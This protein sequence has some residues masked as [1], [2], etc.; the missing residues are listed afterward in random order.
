MRAFALVLA[1]KRAL[2][3]DIVMRTVVAAWANID[4]FP[5][6]SNMRVWLF[7]M[8]R[9]VYYA[10]PQPAGRAANDFGAVGDRLAPRTNPVANRA[11]TRFLRAFNALPVGQR[12][13]LV[14]TGPEG[15]SLRDA[16]TVCGCSP[17]KIGSHV[18]VGHRRLAVVLSMD[19]GGAE[20]VGDP[21]SLEVICRRA[22]S[23][24]LSTHIT[25]R[26][27]HVNG[28]RPTSRL[29][30]PARDFRGDAPV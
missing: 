7:R 10:D 25:T 2:A 5:R 30:P 6:G 19:A 15:L 26:L 22:L 17:A 8:L 3:D 4:A 20:P 9:T 23:G 16:A 18:K 28:K 11:E 14:L 27:G 1:G 29:R 12:E 13:A 24:S 21:V